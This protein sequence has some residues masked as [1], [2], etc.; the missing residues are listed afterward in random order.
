[1]NISRCDKKKTIFCMKT[2]KERRACYLAAIFLAGAL[3]IV[4]ICVP[5]ARGESGRI[6][7]KAIYKP[8]KSWMNEIRNECSMCAEVFYSCYIRLIER[9]GAKNEALAFIKLLGEPG[10][11]R[12]FKKAGPVDIAFVDFPFRANENNGC[13]LVNGKPGLINVD[14]LTE[15]T[16]E[17]LKNSAEYAKLKKT[18]PDISLWIGER[19]GTGF[20]KAMGLGEGGVRFSLPYR[21]TEGCR[22]C[23]DVGK[24]KIGFDFDAQGNFLGRKVIELKTVN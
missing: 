14:D 24:A 16:E 7:E 6:T 20:V 11:M 17:M 10:Y 12:A 19:T 18:Y 1:M 23:R 9:Y 15:I 13:F 21:L 5:Y 8:K 22:A 4:H 2:K 3:L